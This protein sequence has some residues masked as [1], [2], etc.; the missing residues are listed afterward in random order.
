MKLDQKLVEISDINHVIWSRAPQISCLL[1]G[2]YAILYDPDSGREKFINQTGFFVWE[3]MDGVSC[4]DDLAS[5]IGQNCGIPVTDEIRTDTL[6]FAV[7]MF[8]NGFSIFSDVS[9]TIP[10]LKETCSLAKDVPR[11]IDLSLTGRCNL[12]C[13]Y[14]FYNDEMVG[15]K[16]L[17]LETWLTFISELKKHAIRSVTLSGGEV[18]LRSDLWQ[19]IDAVV[20]AR[21]RYSILSNGTLITEKTLEDFSKGNRRGRLNSIQVSIDGAS[22][23]VHDASRGKGS[24]EKAVRGLCLLKEANFPVNVRV[25]F[26]RHNV[27]EIERIAE[28]LLDTIHLDSFGCNEAIPMGSGCARRDEVA[29]TPAE[30]IRAMRVLERLKAKY[31]GRINATAGPL[32]K[33]DKFRDMERALASGWRTKKWN[34]GT[35]SACG[36]AYNKLAVHH[37]GVIS[38]CNMLKI[39]LGRIN[40]DSLSEIWTKHPAL[41]SLRIR[42]S[43]IMREVPECT[44]CEWAEV[45][46]GS[47]PSTAYTRTGNLISANLDDCYRELLKGITLQDWEELFE[48][49]EKSEK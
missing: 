4:I 31:P 19:L 9:N 12:H 13:D 29:L 45:C 25:T 28:F 15:R 16:D 5:A 44:D 26:N 39:E 40:N 21:M 22:A 11:E 7:D 14:C 20:D 30:Q 37:D 38:P 34:M 3:A 17:P 49:H 2:E 6:S 27:D 48:W 41:K 36:C 33:L 1:D 18:F 23:A 47:C 32:V 8:R 24:F 46:N 35:L 42:R 43:V 10:A